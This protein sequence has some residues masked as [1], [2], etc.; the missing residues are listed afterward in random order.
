MIKQNPEKNRTFS[1]RL[2]LFQ[3]SEYYNLKKNILK[4]QIKSLNLL[5]THYY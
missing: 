3:G 5:S 2:N 4:L 1:F